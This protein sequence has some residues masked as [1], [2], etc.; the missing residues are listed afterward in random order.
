[1][2]LVFNAVVIEVLHSVP[3]IWPTSGLAK[4]EHVAEMTIFQKCKGHHVQRPNNQNK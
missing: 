1:M 3:D 2:L 4:I